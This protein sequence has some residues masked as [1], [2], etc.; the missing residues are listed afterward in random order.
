MKHDVVK[1]VTHL[2]L[3][4]RAF[5]KTEGDVLEMGT[6]YFSTM[7][8]RWL[9]EMAH[10]EL[11]SCEGKKFWYDR[12][13][14]KPKSFHHMLFTPDWDWAPIERPWGLAFIDH[15]PNERRHV[16]VKR[17]VDFADIIVMHDTEPQSDAG[18]LYSRIWPLF[19]YRY[20]YTKYIPWA[21]AVSNKVDLSILK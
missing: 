21:S 10:R 15:G 6:G 4:V 13:M 19:K 3:L 11:Y 9:C 16:D 1:M 8:L 18:Y 7:I 20:D 2:T 12:Q 17:L 14:L 5:D